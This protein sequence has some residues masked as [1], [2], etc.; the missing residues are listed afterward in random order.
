MLPETKQNKTK[1]NKTKPN[2]T[3]DGIST[4]LGRQTFLKQD[5]KTTKREK[6]NK[7]DSIKIK[8]SSSKDNIQR[9]KRE[10]TD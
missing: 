3:T 9:V 2:Q 1:Q 5:V 8:N 4:T 7:L 6:F 10:V